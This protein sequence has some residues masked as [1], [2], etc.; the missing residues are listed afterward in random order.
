MGEAKNQKLNLDAAQLCT[1]NVKGK[2]VY[3]NKNLYKS[4]WYVQ[5]KLFRLP[6]SQIDWFCCKSTFPTCCE[7]KINIWSGC[8]AQNGMCVWGLGFRVSWKSG[9][10][11]PWCCSACALAMQPLVT[12]VPGKSKRGSAPSSLLQAECSDGH[13]KGSPKYFSLKLHSVSPS[14]TRPQFSCFCSR[15]ASLSSAPTAPTTSFTFPAPN[16]YYP[17][18]KTLPMR[19]FFPTL[20]TKE[21]VK[22]TKEKEGKKKRT[23]P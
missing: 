11:Q 14:S 8:K 21:Y 16:F 23:R 9:T 17:I 19:S 12:W 22:N 13:N 2:Q 4:V 10:H 6:D 20:N 7:L 5:R 3:W 15:I 18:R 1:C